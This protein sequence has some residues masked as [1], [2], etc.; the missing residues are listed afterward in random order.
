MSW[1]LDEEKLLNIKECYSREKFPSISAHYIY[2]NDND[3]IDNIKCEEVYFNWDISKNIGII[4]SNILLKLIEGKKTCGNNKYNFEEGSL[5]NL[6]LEPDYIQSYSETNNIENDGARF[7]KPFTVIDDL[8]LEP[9]IFIFHELNSLYFIFRQTEKKQTPTSI[10]KFL[11]NVPNKNKST[12]RRVIVKLP[13]KKN[14]TRK[15][16]EKNNI[17]IS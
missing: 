8:H 15:Y 3:C 11:D 9:T 10:L 13:N 12:T 6:T 5:F 4:P 16:L 1:V 17:N 2:I 7:L 14:K